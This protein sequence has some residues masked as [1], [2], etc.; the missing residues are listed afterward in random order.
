M[1][2]RSNSMAQD[3]TP[4]DAESEGAEPEDS[5]H[6]NT[7]TPNTQNH[8]TDTQQATEQVARP[9]RNFLFYATA[10][11]GAVATGAAVWPLVNSMNPSADVTAVS[12]IQVDLTDVPLGARVTLKWHG[13]PIFLDHRTQ[14]RIDLARADDKNMDLIDPA[15]DASRAQRPEWLVVIG[16]CTHLGCI[17][18]GQ[19]EGEPVGKWKGWFCVCHGSVYDTAGR[20]RRG[21]APRNLDL[22]PYEYVSDTLIKIG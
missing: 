9:R 6:Q 12:T 3:K 10:G 13:R 4:Q 14:E 15:T 5:E 2:L 17:P 8:S 19:K 21:P 20:V 7:Q 1:V 11:A 22:P 18:L 16:V